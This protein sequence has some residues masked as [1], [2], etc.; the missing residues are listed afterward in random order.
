MP[1]SV[2]EQCLAAFFDLFAGL[3]AYPLKKRMP[4]WD[5]SRQEL[6][7]LVQIDGGATPRRRR[8]EQRL[9]RHDAD[10][11]PRQHSRRDSCR[12]VDR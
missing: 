1:L 11:N 12:I 9:R 10:R 2:R 8:C 5:V 7:A 3:S 4:N 6:P